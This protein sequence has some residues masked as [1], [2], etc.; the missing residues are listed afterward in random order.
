MVGML[1]FQGFRKPGEGPG[2]GGWWRKAGGEEGTTGRRKLGA[3]AGVPVKVLVRQ[4]LGHNEDGTRNHHPTG[5]QQM[6]SV[7]EGEGQR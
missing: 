7:P 2:W 4:L 6:H 5:R 1:G 3:V